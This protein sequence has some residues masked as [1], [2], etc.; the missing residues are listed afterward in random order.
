MGDLRKPFYYL[1]DAMAR[2]LMPERD[3][4]AFV[5]S[6]ELTLSATVAGLRITYGSYEDLGAMDYHPIAEGSRSVIG[7]LDLE[8][9]DAWHVLRHGNWTISSAKSPPGTFRHIE[10]YGDDGH[11]VHRDDLVICRAEMERFEAALELKPEE[12]LP[13]RRGAPIRFDWDGFWIE[14][15]RYIHEEGVPETQNALADRMGDW[16]SASQSAAPD[17]STIKKKI[18]P[19]WQQIKPAS[20]QQQA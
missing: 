16:F 7:T 12:D 9:D 11:V 17:Q 6:D 3:I 14:L 13:G 18:R 19:L 8:Q 1:D 15:C 20:L 5:L 10:K 2:W 4:M